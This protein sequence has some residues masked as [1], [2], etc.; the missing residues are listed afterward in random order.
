[1]QHDAAYLGERLASP[2]PAVGLGDLTP[3]VAENLGE[4]RNAHG[5]SPV[6]GVVG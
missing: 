1:M 6:Y 4:P 5:V 3:C 2:H